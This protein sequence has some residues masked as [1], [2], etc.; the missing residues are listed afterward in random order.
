MYE[1][2][3]ESTDVQSRRS[4]SRIGRAGVIAVVVSLFI[5]VGLLLPA[6]A[7]IREAARRAQCQN[8]LKQLA[9]ATSN[10]ESTFKKLPI[11]IQVLTGENDSAETKAGNWSWSSFLKPYLEQQRFYD[12]LDVR[13]T[14]NLSDRLGDKLEKR[15][16]QTKDGEELELDVGYVLWELETDLPGYPDGLIY[17]CPSDC[18][19]SRQND[20]RHGVTDSRGRTVS[21]PES[22]KLFNL[23]ISNYVAANSSRQCYGLAAGSANGETISLE[24]DGVFHAKR[25]IRLTNIGDGQANTIL[26]SERICGSQTPRRDRTRFGRVINAGAATIFGSRGIGNSAIDGSTTNDCADAWGAPDV[27]FGAWGGINLDDPEKPW[28]KFQGVSSS[29]PGGVNIA[30]G[31][32]SVRFFTNIAVPEQLDEYGVFEKP[33]AET[34]TENVRQVRLESANIWR[35]LISI[36]DGA[37]K[38]LSE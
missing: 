7:Q 2:S 37:N 20:F 29:H 4:G 30:L 34:S 25:P 8:N 27:L 21:W 23:G 28:R 18:S 10:Y 17:R 26:L 1:P 5:L 9:L 32:G 16:V 12:G 22:D 35:L 11:G 13:Y 15:V 31:D 33:E 38:D 24:P 19:G 14:N 3:I 6:I 36:D